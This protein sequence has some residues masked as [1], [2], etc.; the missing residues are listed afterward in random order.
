MAVYGVPRVHGQA[1]AG[2][3]VQPTLI[4][5]KVTATGKFTVSS[6]GGTSAFTDGG[7]EK[8]VKAVESQGSIVWLGNRTDDDYF[9]AIVDG[10]TINKGD[11]VAGSGVTTGYGALKA[12]LAAQCGGVV[13]D[14][15][16]AEYTSITNQGAFAA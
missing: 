7:Y 1:A 10:N 2:I 16:V 13:G 8:A 4:G 6:G 5:I 15:T 9:F 12:V 14:Y 11:G 3:F